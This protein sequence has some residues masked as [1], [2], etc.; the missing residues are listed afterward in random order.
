MTGPVK[1]ELVMRYPMSAPP[2]HGYCRGSG[3]SAKARLHAVSNERREG[4]ELN[5]GYAQAIASLLFPRARAGLSLE[6]NQNSRGVQAESSGQPTHTRALRNMRIHGP[7]SPHSSGCQELLTVRQTRSGCG[8]VMV[9][10]PS[11]VGR[12]GM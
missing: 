5:C 7:P 4:I 6:P 8:M 1:P 9:K 11:G 12:P 10:R 2:L 3:L